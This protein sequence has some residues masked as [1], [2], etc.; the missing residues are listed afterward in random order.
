[1]FQRHIVPKLQA[2]LK[3]TPVV[4]LHGARQTGKTTLARSLAEDRS[5]RRYFTL[6]DATVLAAVRSD[7]VSFIAGV[8]EPI[9]LDEAQRAPGLFLAI[10]AAVDHD[11]TPGRFLLTGSANALL[12]PKVAEALAGRVEIIT[13]WPLSQREIESAPGS[14][15]DRVF[16][17][18]LHPSALETTVRSTGR[19]IAERILLGGYPE[20]LAR[21]TESRRAAWFGSYLSTILDRDIRDLSSIEGLT[22]LPRLLA[23]IASRFSGHANYADF[24]RSLSIP[25][26]SL[27]RYLALLRTIFLIIEVPAWSS[28]LGLRLAKAPKL[29]LAD[30]GLAC[31]VL[32]TNAERLLADSTLRGSLLKSFVAAELLKQLGASETTARLFH[33]RTATGREVDLVL[34][35]TQGRVVGI[36]VKSAASVRPADFAGLHALRDAAGAKFLRGMVL[37]DGPQVVPFA[38]QFSAVPL[39]ALWTSQPR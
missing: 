5:L 35:D 13:L 6:D 2:A 4:L 26:S 24:S 3:D 36:E 37:Y 17:P 20:P 25:Q 31:H 21:P 23:L 8:R 39:S 7:P 19:T 10:K 28:N 11:R 18:E 30:S 9:I 16:D 38:E 22:D 12:I 33:F 15:V 1:M 27:K 14:F 29:L 32:G 34:E